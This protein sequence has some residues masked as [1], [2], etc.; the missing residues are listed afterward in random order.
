MP[1]IRLDRDGQFSFRG[2]P[3]FRREITDVFF[4]KLEEDGQ[5]GYRIRLGSEL[6][7][8][9]VEDAPLRVHNILVGDGRAI[10]VLDGGLS[11]PLDP[12]TLR[13]EGDVPWCRAR[14]LRARFTPVAA[15][16]LATEFP[17]FLPREA[18][19]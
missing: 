5:G 16:A 2:A 17:G 12:S 11:E 4:E 7:P 15:L 6:A 10:L 9:D 18:S 13:F 19:P 8:V 14:G 1:E 3:C